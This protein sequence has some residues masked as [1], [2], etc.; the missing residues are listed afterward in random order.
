MKRDDT[1]F[2]DMFKDMDKKNTGF[3]SY[4]EFV[5]WMMAADDENCSRWPIVLIL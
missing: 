1:D 3:V 2:N 5:D 4:D